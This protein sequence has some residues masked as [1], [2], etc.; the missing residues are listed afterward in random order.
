MD[1]E[2]DH[3][4]LSQRKGEGELGDLPGVLQVHDAARELLE[5]PGEHRRGYVQDTG[6]HA[7]HRGSLYPLDDHLHG[8]AGGGEEVQALSVDAA[9][10]DDLETSA[11]CVRGHL[12]QSGAEEQA[13]QSPEHVLELLDG[14]LLGS[15]RRAEGDQ[16][17]VG[18]EPL[19]PHLLQE[20]AALPPPRVGR[21]ASEEEQK[22]ED[23]CEAGPER[24]RKLLLLRLVVRLEDVSE[25]VSD[26]GIGQR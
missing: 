12:L 21:V 14:V 4:R 8:V 24:K 5:D 1:Q 15:V 17:A 16:A 11:P 19:A 26:D 2:Q 3:A 6:A 25:K 9:H 22:P 23:R 20:R 10:L 18:V 7:Q 13:H